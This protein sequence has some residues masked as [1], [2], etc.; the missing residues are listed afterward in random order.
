M[1]TCNKCKLNK[2]YKEFNLRKDSKDG[3]R[4]ECKDC[5]KNSI[6]KDNEV[7]RNKNY[8][9]K[10]KGIILKKSN[11]RGISNRN[12]DGKR[13]KL[14][15]IKETLAVYEKICTKCLVIKP[16]IDFNKDKSKK[17]GL[18]SHCITCKNIYFVNRRKIDVLFKITSYLRSSLS[19]SISKNKLVRK[20]KTMYILG[21]TFIFF[22][23]YLELKFIENMS[24]NNYGEWHMDHIIPISHGHTED[25]IYKL[26]HYTNFQPLW[27]LDNLSKG[28]RYVG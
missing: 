14:S 16:N 11:E 12:M 2:D 21:C 4:N 15:I 25:E 6:N 24:W 18:N 9:I 7:M 3:Y 23:E 27:K 22:K 10:N 1:K 17:D 5:K 26:S 19:D 28:N 8:Y 13:I 20:H